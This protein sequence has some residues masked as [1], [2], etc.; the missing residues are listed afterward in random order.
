[1]TCEVCQQMSDPD[2]DFI[3]KVARRMFPAYDL[4]FDKLPA[5]REAEQLI[6]DLHHTAKCDIEDRRV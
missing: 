1:M 3:V 2:L 5:L 6:I 4:L